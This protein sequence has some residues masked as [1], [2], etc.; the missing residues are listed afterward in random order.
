MQVNALHKLNYTRAHLEKNLRGEPNIVGIKVAPLNVLLELQLRTSLVISQMPVYSA[1]IWGCRSR[2]PPL[3][4]PMAISTTIQVVILR[5][6]IPRM[7]S[8]SQKY[9]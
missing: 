7:K 1:N 9:I 3:N 8:A 5:D 4:P 2:W 6:E